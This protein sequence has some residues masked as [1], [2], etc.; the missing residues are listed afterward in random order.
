[1]KAVLKSASCL[2]LTRHNGTPDIFSHPFVSGDVVHE[3]GRREI[4]V[5]I[6]EHNHQGVVWVLWSVR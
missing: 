2:N 5:V 4:G 6:Y 1:M 3:F